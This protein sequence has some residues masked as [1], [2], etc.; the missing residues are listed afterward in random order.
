MSS[1]ENSTMATSAS[2]CQIAS[3]STKQPEGVYKNPRLMHACTS[4]VGYTVHLQTNDGKIWEGIFRTYNPK[5]TIC[6]E[7]VVEIK[8]ADGKE[9]TLYEALTEGKKLVVPQAFFEADQIVRL[10]ATNIDL[11]YATKKANS[12]NKSLVTD[13][14]ISGFENSKQSGNANGVRQ[15]EVWQDDN[16]D[17]S[18]ENALT[19]EDTA[20]TGQGWGANEMFTYNEIHHNV[21][22]NFDKD[23]INYTIALKKKGTDDWREKEEKAEAKANEIESSGKSRL[24]LAKENDDGDEE[25]KFSAVVRPTSN[26]PSARRVPPNKTGPSD[27]S[28]ADNSNKQGSSGPSSAIG[29]SNPNSSPQS[30]NSQQ[31]QQTPQR[32]P[33]SGQQAQ[34]APQSTNKQEHLSSQS[35][36]THKRSNNL[37]F[38]HGIHQ[39]NRTLRDDRVDDDSNKYS[40]MHRPVANRLNIGTQNGHKPNRHRQHIDRVAR[41]DSLVKFG[42]KLTI[43]NSP[44]PSPNHSQAMNH[45]SNQM[46]N[47][48][49]G[50]YQQSHNQPHQPHQK[51][52]PAQQHQQM[53]PSQQRQ[54]QPQTQLSQQ[55][56]QQQQQPQQQQQQS[57]QQPQ[58]QQQPHQPQQHQQAPQ[59]QLPTSNAQSKQQ[60][61]PVQQQNLPSS[62]PQNQQSSQPVSSN[63]QTAATNSTPS[64]VA[65]TSNVN[66]S[67]LSERSDT[68]SL[69]NQSKEHQSEI[70]RKS[71]LNPDAK[72]FVYKP[73]SPATNQ[74]QAN[75]LNHAN[76]TNDQPNSSPMSQGPHNPYYTQV[77]VF[78][79]GLSPHQQQHHAAQFM[80]NHSH[81]HFQNQIH[82]MSPVAPHFPQQIPQ[83]YVRGNF[84]NYHH[85]GEHHSNVRPDYSQGAMV[86]TTSTGQPF[87]PPPAT[88]PHPM[89]AYTPSPQ[90]AQMIYSG[91]P[92]SMYPMV[93]AGFPQ[94][95]HT[96]MPNPP[97]YDGSGVY[98]PSQNYIM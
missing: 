5:F 60:Q 88:G 59:Q 85:R 30:A 23:M 68:S 84:Q 70:A 58:Q 36:Q 98:M 26:P 90:Q 64:T 45:L 78:P 69:S 12:N 28:A 54:Q 51:V 92:Q 65:R 11:N 89:N 72:E 9:H 43:N 66:T 77:P 94:H 87:I 79:H 81:P 2:S 80:P 15:L 46:Q 56:Q 24:R 95:V 41:T 18:D 38:Q 17:P 8:E 33:I 7:L 35:Q 73:K 13:A 27:I 67:T 34:Q 93:Q 83:R 52:T 71:K 96:V 25:E 44:R 37:N 82:Y 49:S 57:Q 75:A 50:S 76:T 3:A 47:M 20:L 6:L 86:P 62:G 1:Q 97:P 91:P 21:K 39:P 53:Q 14:D 29:N 31:S 74:A 63:S 4:I 10:S 42:Q 32:T 40:Q 61:A 48:S 55:Q 22:S 16:H 19:L